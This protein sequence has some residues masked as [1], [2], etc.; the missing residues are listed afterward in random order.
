MKA[1]H[2]ALVSLLAIGVLSLLNI[3]ASLICDFIGFIFPAYMSFK[4]IESPS[5]SD[6]KQ[7]LT[8]WVVFSFC[9]VTDSFLGFLTS[10][11]P[12]FYFIKLAF[13]VYL[14]H[15]RTQG[16]SLIYNKLIRQMLTKYEANI[17]KKIETIKNQVEGMKK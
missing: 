14:F 4:A 7:W 17:D 10:A 9:T 11:I 8:Y 2:I 13:F 16:A 15:P 5:L 12:F 3:G 1:S 6:D